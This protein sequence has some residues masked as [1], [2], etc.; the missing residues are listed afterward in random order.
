MSGKRTSLQVD[1]PVSTP[2]LAAALG[3]E[4]PK[5]AYRRPRDTPAIPR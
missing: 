1:T 4:E 3:G 2:I 5:Y